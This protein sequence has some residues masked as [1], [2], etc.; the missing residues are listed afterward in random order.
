MYIQDYD[1]NINFKRTINLVYYKTISYDTTD[2]KVLFS[3]F[4]M[5]S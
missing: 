1:Y 4:V 2:I 3:L 5:E